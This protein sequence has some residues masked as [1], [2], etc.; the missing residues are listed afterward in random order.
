MRKCPWRCR[1]VRVVRISKQAWPQG[2]YMFPRS[3][4]PTRV[5]TEGTLVVGKLQYK[6]VLAIEEVLAIEDALACP[7]T[8]GS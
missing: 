7:V 2:E 8:A 6:G 1:T 5:Q 4:V 3:T